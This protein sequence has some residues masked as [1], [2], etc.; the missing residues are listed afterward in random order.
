MKEVALIAGPYLSPDSIKPWEHLHNNSEVDVTAFESKPSKFDTSTLSV[1]VEKLHWIDGKASLFG[2]KYFFAKALTKL[3]LP[4]NIL[5][6]IRKLSEYDVIHILE[7]YHVFSLQAAIVARRSDTH[8]FMSA[9]ENIPYPLYQR[10]PLQWW[11][12]KFVNDSVDAVNTTTPMAKRAL[13]H[14][15]VDHKKIS[16]I[17]NAVDT[18]KFKPTSDPDISDL[19]LPNDIEDS[20]N[21]LFVHGLN[22]QKGVP[23]LLDAFEHIRTNFDARLIL[24]GED[25]LSEDRTEMIRNSDDIIWQERIPYS[26]MPKV[27][28]ISDISILP[29]V[30]MV[31][32]QE[33]FGVAVI[34]AMACGLPTVVTDVGGLPYVVEAEETS[35]VIQERSVDQIVSALVELLESSQLRSR[36]GKNGRERAVSKFG[37]EVVADQLFEYYENSA[38]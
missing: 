13:I 2:H 28:N 8:L 9:G 11:T 21:I 5:T 22:E 32:N 30:T 4:S 31:N 29:S 35:K 24:L 7:N 37:K 14:E 36:L 38:E 34:E 1:P 3:R 10:N 19:S 17:P 16:V 20:L 12:K 23:Y 26:E 18:S 33:Q 6:G 15:G 27:Y 25:K